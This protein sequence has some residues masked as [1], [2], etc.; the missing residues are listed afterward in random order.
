MGM[1]GFDSGGGG[2]GGGGGGGGVTGNSGGVG[3]SVGAGL[4][5]VIGG[6]FSQE[7]SAAGF[8]LNRLDDG[9]IKLLTDSCGGGVVDQQI[10]DPMTEEHLKS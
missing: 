5:G 8:D 4:P 9:M 2:P 3:G 7:M 1:L 10:A 6:V